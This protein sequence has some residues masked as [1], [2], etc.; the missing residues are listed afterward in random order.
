MKHETIDIGELLYQAIK[1]Y[2]P[3]IRLTEQ[4]EKEYL[5]SLED[6]DHDDYGE[7]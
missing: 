4:E 7:T 5:Q 3:V 1:L 6:G 2:E